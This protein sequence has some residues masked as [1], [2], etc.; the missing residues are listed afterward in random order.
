M[1]NAIQKTNQFQHF[2]LLYKYCNIKRENTIKNCKRKRDRQ[3]S[4]FELSI[5]FW[6]EWNSKVGFL[7]LFFRYS[8]RFGLV[9]I[10]CIFISLLQYWILFV[11]FLIFEGRNW[12]FFFCFTRCA[13][14]LIF[15]FVLIVQVNFNS[16]RTLSQ[17]FALHLN[18][19]LHVQWRKVI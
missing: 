8:S 18:R 14:L 15:I 4:N 2:I 10:N 1:Q 19:S 3:H 13:K 7:Y 11:C 17:L 6:L 9:E 12:K 5:E 16:N